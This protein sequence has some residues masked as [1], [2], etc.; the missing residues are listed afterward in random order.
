M[1]INIAWHG[2]KN[3]FTKLRFWKKKQD[4]Q[5]CIIFTKKTTFSSLPPH[6][7][8][9]FVTGHFRTNTYYYYILTNMTQHQTVTNWTAFIRLPDQFMCKAALTSLSRQS[10][11]CLQCA[12]LAWGLDKLAAYC[13]NSKKGP[14]VMLT[15]QYC[16]QY[17]CTQLRARD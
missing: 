8:S 4:I 1:N 5:L 2:T 6:R 9:S 17:S 10:S 11:R 12:P 15:S 13:K 16:G 3:I 14:S 7:G